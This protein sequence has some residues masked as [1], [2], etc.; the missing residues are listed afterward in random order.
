MSL[1]RKQQILLKRAQAEAGLPDAEY[2][3][4]IEIVTALPGCRSSK[5][6]RLSDAHLDALLSYFEAIFWHRVDTENWHLQSPCKG[7]G[8]VFQRRA[9]WAERNQKCNTSRDRFAASRWQS[10]IAV[11]EKQLGD[12]G[13]GSAYLLAIRSN[14]SPFN[15]VAYL[16]ALRRTLKSKRI[17]NSACPF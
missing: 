8:D 15:S 7:L 5:D 17:S 3:D 1:S 11:A 16:A 2:R 12:L 6:T 10:E 13:F 9:F 4:A 14:V